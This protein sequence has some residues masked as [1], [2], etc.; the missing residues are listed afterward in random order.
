MI[1]YQK[2]DKGLYID[3]KNDLETL[4]LI[5]FTKGISAQQITNEEAEVYLKNL[6]EEGYGIFGFSDN[7]LISALLTTPISHDK[8]RPD[9][10]KKLYD[11][12]DTLYIDEVL[13]DENFRGQ[14]L[15]KK[16][17]QHFEEHLDERIK[18]VLLRVW[19]ENKPAVA[20]YEKMGF[21]ICGEI[22]QEKVRP[23]TN[24]KFIMHKNYMLKKY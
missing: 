2:A 11:D 22:T 5:T 4:Y 3:F 24:E 23:K 13:V 6:F 20:L 14:G 21:Q 18:N 8:D 19:K 9:N 16:L 12:N 17:M 7:K 15:G 10:F 1:T